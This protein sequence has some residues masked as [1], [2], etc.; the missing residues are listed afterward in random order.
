LKKAIAE[1]DYCFLSPIILYWN[2]KYAQQF[3]IAFHAGF[4]VDAYNKNPRNGGKKVAVIKLTREPF[5]QPLFAIKKKDLVEEGGLWGSV[6]EF[7]NVFLDKNKALTRNS[8][9]WVVKFKLV[10][11]G[12][13][14]MEL[15]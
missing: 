15:I 8:E 12:E 2:D 5:K 14:Q 3:I 6:D 10:S 4:L 13:K 9:V 11:V 1:V 7:I